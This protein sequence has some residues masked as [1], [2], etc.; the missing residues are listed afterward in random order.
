[1]FELSYIKNKNEKL[2][3]CLK[4][5]SDFSKL[6][7]Y[8]PIYGKFFNL[9]ESNHSSINLE[10]K[11]SI[12]DIDE[13]K[14][15]NKFV[16]NIK[17]G[18]NIIKKNSFFKYSPILDPIKYLVGK[19]AGKGDVLCLPS[20]NNTDNTN[21]KILDKNNAAYVDGFF[22][23]L[24]SKL[25]HNHGF[26]HGIDFYGSFLGIKQ[27]FAYNI[28][29]DIEYLLNSDYFHEHK[30]K[31]YNLE[32]SLDDFSIDTRKHKEKLH[33]TKNSKSLSVASIDN[34]TLDSIF[35]ANEEKNND[36]S[37]K[38][39]YECTLPLKK[40]RNTD[41]TCSS[42]SSNTTSSSCDDSD[43]DDSLSEGSSCS[44]SS[45]E[46][47]NANIY[48]FPVQVICLELLENT[49]DS[50]IAK[51]DNFELDEWK[52]CLIQIIMTLL[53]Y[54]KTFGLTHNDLH[55]NN[56]MFVT[57]NKKYLYYLYNK[58]YYKVPTYGRIYKIIDFGRAIYSYKGRQICSDSFHP[59]GDAA[60]QYNFGTYFTEGKK[61]IE[62][63]N[64]FDLCRLACSLYD[65]FEDEMEEDGTT[66]DPITK[67][68]M[69]WCT[70]DNNKNI[71]YKKNGDERYPDFKL[72]KMIAR[73]VHNHTPEK[74]METLF[75]NKFVTKKK[76]IP[77]KAKIMNIDDLPSYK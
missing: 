54:Q 45:D 56:I 25:L 40:T 24:S 29:D 58:Q 65:L 62:P 57:T 17:N 20:F 49:L 60:T 61:K 9:N 37:E 73:T 52:S 66:D 19:Y 43:E 33:L 72:Y 70:D 7:N 26:I 15:D 42:R 38:L 34:T 41:S 77:K 23:F 21:T 2:F 46:N 64:S 14:T 71:L 53:A 36:P 8:I 13:K 44:S 16:C 28:S 48:N 50:L 27:H 59:K 31:I 51:E 69:E 32:H 63:N 5:K 55:T 74:Q 1:M 18:D 3:A 30:D 39:I 11:W 10:N 76:K 67:L 35:N 4:E 22:S 75:F 6:Q 68:I 47:I 12:D